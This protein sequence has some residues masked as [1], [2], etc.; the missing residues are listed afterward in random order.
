MLVGFLEEE[1]DGP[2]RVLKST[3]GLQCLILGLVCNF[4]VILG[5]SVIVS[6]TAMNGSSS[7]RVLCTRSGSKKNNT[8][9]ISITFF[10]KLDFLDAGRPTTSATA[11][12]I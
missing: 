1:E 9:Y 2:D 3:Q 7:F 10:C 6:S 12:H 11:L 8:W 5:L 4:L